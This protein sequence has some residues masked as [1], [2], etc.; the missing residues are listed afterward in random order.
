[1]CP[2]VPKELERRLILTVGFIAGFLAIHPFGDGYGRLA[3]LMVWNLLRADGATYPL[4]L[5]KWHREMNEYQNGK[6]N[7]SA[8]YEWVLDEIVECMEEVMRL[9]ARSAMD[10]VSR[11]GV[12]VQSCEIKAL[13]AKC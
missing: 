11:R 5:P 10:P 2:Q 9:D 3:R 7:G 8:L 12:C 1:M 6:R 13:N 4:T